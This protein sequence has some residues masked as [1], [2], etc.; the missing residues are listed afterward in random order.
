V[1]IT[2]YAVE[3]RAGSGAWTRTTAAASSTS[4]TLTSL[5]AGSY[6]V[7]VRSLS[8]SLQSPSVSRSVTVR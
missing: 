8:D 7:R 5:P 2:G 4:L 6:T 3:Y 1:P